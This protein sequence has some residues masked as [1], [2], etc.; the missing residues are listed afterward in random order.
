M[1]RSDRQNP[2]QWPAEIVDLSHDP[3]KCR[4][5]SYWSSMV[6]S[7]TMAD[8][9]EWFLRSD[10]RYTVRSLDLTVKVLDAKPVNQLLS[11]VG[12]NLEHLGLKLQALFSSQWEY[13]RKGPSLFLRSHAS[14]TYT[15]YHSH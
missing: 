10:A 3:R 11:R 1:A 8:F 9:I 14:V 4:I 12:P 7:T 6:W 2:L 15:P 13:D 5:A